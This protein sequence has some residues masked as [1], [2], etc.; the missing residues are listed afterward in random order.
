[1]ARVAEQ[2]RLGPRPQRAASMLRVA[3]SARLEPRRQCAAMAFRG[4]AL[5]DGRMG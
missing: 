3:G 5:P 1:M 2:A 4:R